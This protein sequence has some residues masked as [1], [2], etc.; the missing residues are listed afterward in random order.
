[1]Q[2]CLLIFV[3]ADVSYL[4]TLYSY[5]GFDRKYLNL[6]QLDDSAKVERTGLR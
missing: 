2:F 6:Q 4:N 1:M 5:V 3:D